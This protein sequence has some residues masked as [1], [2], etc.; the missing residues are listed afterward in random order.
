MSPL[1]V[2]NG[3]DRL[4][5]EW[6]RCMLSVFLRICSLTRDHEPTDDRRTAYQHERGNSP[7][8]NSGEPEPAG[9]VVERFLDVMIRALKRIRAWTPIRRFWRRFHCE[10]IIKH[11]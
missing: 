2:E 6:G 5:P 11:I 1:E 7:S 4:G 3:L 9:S 8:R 10:F